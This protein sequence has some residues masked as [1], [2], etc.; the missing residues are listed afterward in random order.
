[1]KLSLGLKEGCLK[2]SLTTE[3]EKRVLMISFDLFNPEETDT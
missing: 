3:R 1:M 2:M